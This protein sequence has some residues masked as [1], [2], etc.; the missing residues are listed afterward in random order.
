MTVRYV[1]E[2]YWETGFVYEDIEID[3]G[4]YEIIIPRND[5]PLVQA[6]PVEIRELSLDTLRLRLRALEDDDF[7]IVEPTTHNYT[8]PFDIGGVTLAAVVEILAPYTIT[9]EDGIYSVNI[10]GGNT[11]AADR[12]NPNSVGVRTSNSAGLTDTSGFN[13]DLDIINQG[14]QDSS[15]FIPHTTDLP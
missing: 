8:A 11:N 10:T 7:G 3:W 4:T 5:M 15:L 14:I 12:V 6:S 9:F 1:E 13:T 2:G